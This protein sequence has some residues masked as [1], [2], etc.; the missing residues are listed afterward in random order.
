MAENKIKLGFLQEWTI[1]HNDTDIKTIWDLGNYDIIAENHKTAIFW[2]KNICPNINQKISII[3]NEK[4]NHFITAIRIKM[5]NGINIIAASY[6]RAFKDK[7]DC[8]L[9]FNDL[10]KQLLHWKNQ[11]KKSYILLNGD[12]N[13]H[14]TMWSSSHTDRP[15][16]ILHDIVST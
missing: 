3:L 8:Q 13:A 4:L 5:K 7:M 15:G 10:Y 1:H 11:Y 14:H 12:F 16:M 2:D 9:Q 6:Y